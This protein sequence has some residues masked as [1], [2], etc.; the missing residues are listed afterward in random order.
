MPCVKEEKP[1]ER[2]SLL[3]RFCEQV[4]DQEDM[5]SKNSFKENHVVHIEAGSLAGKEAQAIRGKAPRKKQ[6]RR[7]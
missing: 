7:T 4:A 1:S 5:G 3:V 2:G 6:G